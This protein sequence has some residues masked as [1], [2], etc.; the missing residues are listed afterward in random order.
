M[1]VNPK[2]RRKAKRKTASKGVAV[3]RRRR[4]SPVAKRK[5]R[6]NPSPRNTIMNQ[7]QNAAVGAAGAVAVDVAIAK[8]PIPANMKVGAM[9][10]ATQ[11]LVSI[12]I[13]M[14][15]SNVMKN[16]KLGVQIAEGGL[17]V[18]LHGLMKGAVAKAIPMAGIDNG[19]LGYDDGLLAYDEMAGYDD[20][21]WMSPAQ[22]DDFDEDDDLDL[23]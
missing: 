16:K 6:R 3:R 10:T 22:V 18:A 4:A 13:G 5:Y 21:G 17:T 1:L 12:G 19:L 8:L 9:A 14:L 2:K 20:L 23:F 11:G 15:T 7:V